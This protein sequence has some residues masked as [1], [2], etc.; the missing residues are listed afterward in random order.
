MRLV[1]NTSFYYFCTCACPRAFISK[2]CNEGEDTKSPAPL[3]HWFKRST[4]ASEGGLRSTAKAVVV[5]WYSSNLRVSP[6]DG[7]LFLRVDFE[8][9]GGLGLGLRKF[10]SLPFG[11]WL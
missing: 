5:V 1:N 8:S 6:C 2:G 9:L 10:F 3:G 11:R 7:V 4:F